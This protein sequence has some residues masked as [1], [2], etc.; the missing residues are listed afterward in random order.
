MHTGVALRVGWRYFSRVLMGGLS[1]S[2]ILYVLDVD[3]A[4]KRFSNMLSESES[5]V[6]WTPNSGDSGSDL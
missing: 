1:Y 4:A 3:G 5:D 2:L 6:V